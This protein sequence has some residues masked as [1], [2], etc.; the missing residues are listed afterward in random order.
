MG[1]RVGRQGGAPSSTPRSP[2]VRWAAAM[3]AGTGGRVSP[4]GS[5]RVGGLSAS[6]SAVL[7]AAPLATAAIGPEGG[8]DDGASRA[9]A[10][11]LV[12]LLGCWGARALL[13]L[14]AACCCF[15]WISRIRR[16]DQGHD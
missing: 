9:A 3:S 8:V 12:L 7:M 16:S 1:A 10:G 11:L 4:T 5:R 13:L 6:S 14:G 2:G 15:P